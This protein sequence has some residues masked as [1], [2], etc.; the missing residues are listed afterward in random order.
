MSVVSILAN[1]IAAGAGSLLGSQASLRVACYRQPRPMPRQFAP[2]LD[3]PWRLRYRDV[4]ET[5]GL[6]GISAGQ[7]VLDLGCGTGTFTVELAQMVGE[8]GVVHAVDLQQSLLSETRS[9]LDDV[10]MA[11]RVQ[12]HHAGAYNLPLADESCDLAI[13]IATLSQIPDR[14]A[15]LFELRRVLKPGARLVIS[16]ELPDPAYLPARAM[17]QWAQDTGFV[18]QGKASNIFCYTMVFANDKAFVNDNET[19]G[20]IID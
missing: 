15:A 1:S 2:L 6:A 4:G 16:E 5:L 19:I 11:A 7:T 8:D 14:R 10:G 3:N 9:R 13:L 18:L 20:E 17:R 12:L